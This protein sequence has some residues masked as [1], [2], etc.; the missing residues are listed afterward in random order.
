MCIRDS[1]RG[2]ASQ[3][4]TNA[5]YL[6]TAGYRQHEERDIRTYAQRIIDVK[7]QYE[8]DCTAA[9]ETAVSYAVEIGNRM[10]AIMVYDYSSSVEA[11]LRK[12]NGPKRIYIP[13]SRVINGGA[14]FVQPC[15]EAGH[16]IHFIP[17]ASMMYYMKS[18]DGV[19]MGAESIYPDGTGFNTTGSDIVG[20][21]CDYFHVPLYFISPLIKLDVRPVYGK[22][23]CT[24]INDL[25]SKLE[26]VANPKQV[27]GTIDYTA[28]ELL[29]VSPGFIKAFITEQGVIPATQLYD[30]SMKYIKELRGAD[31]V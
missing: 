29:A 27:K 11:F 5:V 20:L 4:I 28:P 19:F 10:S 8:R 3:A 30:I 24:V 14:P 21:L 31:D 15:L 17:D 26:P 18:C 22:E 6:M 13:E 25:R 23:K 7:K 9:S 1:T 2:E 12:I 16:Q